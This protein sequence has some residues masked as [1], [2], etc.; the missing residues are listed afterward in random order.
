MA[1]HKA[2]ACSRQRAQIPGLGPIGA[3][4]LIMNSPA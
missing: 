4:M 1:R 3:S 2:D